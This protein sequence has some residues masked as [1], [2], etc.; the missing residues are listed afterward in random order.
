MLDATTA[1]REESLV[2]KLQFISPC[3]AKVLKEQRK[4]S[5]L[6][7]K[8]LLLSQNTFPCRKR[9]APIEVVEQGCFFGLMLD[10]EG[11][12]CRGSLDSR[13]S[14]IV[15]HRLVAFVPDARQHRQ[16]KERY[17]G[18][19]LVAV[20]VA[21]VATRSPT[22]NDDD[23]V[24]LSPNLPR[25]GGFSQIC[26]SALGETERDCLG[27]HYCFECCDDALGHSFALHDGREELHVE[28]EAIVVLLQLMAEVAVACGCRAADDGNSPEQTWQL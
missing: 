13:M 5:R 8:P 10:D 7:F 15:E 4:H 3:L 14:H 21:Q 24:S 17:A 28:V 27:L 9:D 11:R 12:S 19:Q 25:R 1:G 22:P 20:E 18:S 2:Q 23:K 16:R 26:L 6:V